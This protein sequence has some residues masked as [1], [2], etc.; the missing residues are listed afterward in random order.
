MISN[1]GHLISHIY[2]SLHFGEHAKLYIFAV[3]AVADTLRNI[4]SPGKTGAFYLF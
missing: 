1:L 3:T 4:K 2:S